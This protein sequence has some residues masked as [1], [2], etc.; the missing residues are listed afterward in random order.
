MGTYDLLLVVCLIGMDGTGKTSHAKA[1]L[2]EL[3]NYG[4]TSPYAWCGGSPRFF[5]PLVLGLK[6]TI[7]KDTKRRERRKRIFI[8]NP[9]LV[10]F[11][12]AIG[13]QYYGLSFRYRI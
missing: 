1:I 6:T 3:A 10:G 13:N 11:T 12:A 2:R 8:L 9:F 5:L 7:M 4:L